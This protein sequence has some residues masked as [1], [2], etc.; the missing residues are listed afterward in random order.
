MSSGL[1]DPPGGRVPLRPR[2]ARRDHAP[3]RSGRGPRP[4]RPRVPGVGGRRRVQRRA[5]AAPLLRPAHRRRDRVRRQRG[6]PAAR[7]LH[8]P[9]RRRHEPHPLGAVRRHRPHGAQR[10]QLHRARL[11]RARRASASPI[12]ATR[13]PRSC[14]PATST[15][16][17]SSARSA[18]AGCTPAASSPRSPTPRRRSSSRRSPR[19]KRHGTVVSYDLNY[20][21]SLWKGDRRRRAGAG[22]QPPDRGARRRDDRQR[23]GLHRLP[24][25]RGRGRRREPDRPRHGLVPGD[26]RA[27]RGGVPEL[28]RRRDDAARGAERDGQ[29]LGGD[30]VVARD[31][32][33]RGDAAAGPR[34]PRPRR[35]R[36]QLRLG[37]RSTGCSSSATSGARSS[38]APPTARSR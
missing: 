26:D 5:R 14:G 16:S 37:P 20:R 19:R 7:G 29:R 2:R 11:R 4:H 3:P 15:G 6:R 31:G 12:A 22:G 17:T 27:R 9:G 33:R 18:C 10:P 25:L 38:T 35:R 8:A 21:P 1:D 36:R 24:R 23:G 32:V 30:R 34:D 13:P 28:R